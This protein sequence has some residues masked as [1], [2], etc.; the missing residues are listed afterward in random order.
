MAKNSSGGGGKVSSLLDRV[1]TTINGSTE[2]EE[3][4]KAFLLERIKAVIRDDYGKRSSSLLDRMKDKVKAPFRFVRHYFL[5]E[6]QEEVDAFNDIIVSDEIEH[7]EEEE[8]EVPS[9]VAETTTVTSETAATQT[10]SAV[11]AEPLRRG[12]E[13]RWAVSAKNVDLSGD[14]HILV[15]DKF[16]DEYDRYLMLLGQ[17][18]LVR[19][20]ALSIVGL[21]TE[22][23]RQTDRG[24][25]LLIKG[26]NARGVWERT[27]VASGI[28]GKDTSYTPL[29]TPI[30][31]VDAEKVVAEAWWEET[32]TVHRSWLKGVQKYGGGDFESKRYLEEG[33]KVLVCETVF[34]PTDK[35]REK[36]RVT[37]RFLRQGATL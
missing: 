27:L 2:L 3:E 33:G 6:A 35:T 19:S 7:D 8:I 29:Q 23:T 28:D 31:T 24:R 5:Q 34:H 13:E 11:G 30:E 21:T 10:A 4:E 32:G 16:K 14:W 9:S 22:E 26:R 12:E 37:W 17:P 1:Q 18:G 25:S 20:V 36:A 15:S